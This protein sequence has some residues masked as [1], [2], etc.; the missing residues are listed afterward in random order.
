MLLTSFLSWSCSD[1]PSTILF[2]IRS[3]LM[4]HIINFPSF[5][6]SVVVSNSEV[7]TGGNLRDLYFQK[8]FS[9]AVLIFSNQFHSNSREIEKIFSS[10]L[11]RCSAMS[12][13][14]VT[15]LQLHFRWF[16]Y[17]DQFFCI[18][19]NRV[20]SSTELKAFFASTNA[21]QHWENKHRPKRYI[22]K[23]IKRLFQEN[24]ICYNVRI[25]WHVLLMSFARFFFFMFCHLT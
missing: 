14:S 18:S 15:I 9:T 21:K 10:W 7:I 16:L 20:T 13:C 4:D 25:Q 6:V 1:N 24:I 17:L 22:W 11:F 8:S 5:R 19:W 12:T 23:A 3:V 2:G